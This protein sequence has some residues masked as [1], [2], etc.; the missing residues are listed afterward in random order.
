M[1]SGLTIAYYLVKRTEGTMSDLWQG[2][3]GRGFGGD[4]GGEDGGYSD[5]RV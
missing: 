5:N 1:P 3:G 4:V 2:S